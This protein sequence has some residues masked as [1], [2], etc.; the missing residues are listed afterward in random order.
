MNWYQYSQAIANALSFFIPYVAYLGFLLSFA[1]L[2][3]TL[4]DRRARLVVQSRKGRWTSWRGEML[5]AVLEVFNNSSRPNS[6]R[7]YR[8]E[9]N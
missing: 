5:V 8:L 2:F 3:L 9:A 4:Y 1:A 7:E 6:V